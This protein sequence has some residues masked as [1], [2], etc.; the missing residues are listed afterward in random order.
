MINEKITQIILPIRPLSNIDINDYFKL[1]NLPTYIGTFPKDYL[2]DIPTSELKNDFSTII[3]LGSSDT[4]GSH[5]VMVCKKD[6][7][8]LYFDSY[9]VKFI[10]DSIKKFIDRCNC[11]NRYLN[12]DQI[13]DFNSILCGYYSMKIIKNIYINGLKI[14][15]SIKMFCENPCLKNKDLADDLYI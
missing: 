11:K 15:D 9:G 3:N 4:G 13:Q 2:K 7:E 5:W 14:K 8:L 12:E 1:I 10:D 6:D